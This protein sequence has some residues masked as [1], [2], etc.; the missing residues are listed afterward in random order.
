MASC[1][2]ISNLL[3]AWIDEELSHGERVIL[4]QHLA[5]C[6]GCRV[7]ARKHQRVAALLFESFG[8]NR[9][10]HDLAPAIIENLPP[11]EPLRIN[12]KPEMGR[13]EV[14]PERTLALTHVIPAVAAMVLCV[15]GV[16]LYLNWPPEPQRAEGA[17][18]VVTWCG[19][20][21]N[22]GSGPVRPFSRAYT[23]NYVRLGQ[24]F[25]TGPKSNLM[26]SLRGPTLLKANEKTRLS[27]TDDRA[28]QLEEGQVWLRVA[29]ENRQFKVYTPAGEVTVLGTVFD[30]IVTGSKAVITVVEGVVQ[31]SNG[32][33]KVRVDSGEQVE[34]VAGHEIEPTRVLAAEEVTRWAETIQPDT[35]ADAVFTETVQMR[36]TEELQAEQVFVVITNQ[37]NG[38]GVVSSFELAWE[39][40]AGNSPH[41]GY[42]I[43]VYNDK[44]EELFSNHVQ[45]ELFEK[46]GRSSVTIPVPGK[47]ISGVNVIHI[48]LVPDFTTGNAKTS[49]S[50]ISAMGI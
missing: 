37:A 17:V 49:F 16:V 44:M 32:I 7:V 28:V 4:E 11:M 26:L 3:Q 23:S 19:G 48:K 42:F 10:K 13:R 5:E 41:C 46:G 8:G 1:A 15:V 30:V 14:K 24:K 39:P 6:P 25:Q 27:V 40:N 35:Q 31:V 22:Q 2:Q 50:R 20:E 29:K 34:M 21:V 12:V 45:G 38:D 18:G 33:S 43:H 9:L 36:G 47:P